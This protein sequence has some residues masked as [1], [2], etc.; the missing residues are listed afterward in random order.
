MTWQFV[1]SPE[2]A[3]DRLDALYGAATGALR[4]CVDRY[5]ESAEPPSPAERASS[6]CRAPPASAGRL[7]AKDWLSPPSPPALPG[8]K[9]EKWVQ[10]PE[11]AP[12]VRATT[13][14]A[15]SATA[16]PH[17]GPPPPGSHSHAAQ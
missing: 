3:V 4:R 7:E 12:A 6:I 15:S 1:N 5:L 10:L 14:G 17:A 13:P 2:E 16:A 11:R 9:M 8:A